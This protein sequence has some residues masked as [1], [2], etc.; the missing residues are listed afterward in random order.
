LS[1]EDLSVTCDEEVLSHIVNNLLSNA[2]KF[3]QDGGIKLD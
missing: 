1:G 3:T 2:C